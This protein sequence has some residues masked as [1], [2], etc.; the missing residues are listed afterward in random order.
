MLVSRGGVLA[1]SHR[2]EKM[3]SNMRSIVSDVILNELNDP[4]ISPLTSVT[5]VQMSGDLQ[6]AKV[7][8]SVLG[9]DAECRRTFAG[10][11]HAVGHIQRILAQRLQVRHCPQIRLR[12]DESLKRSAETIAMIDKLSDQRE[13]PGGTGH[14][15]G[16]DDGNSEGTDL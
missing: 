15:T 2:I 11:E 12:L 16:Q 3:A 13:A 4:R 5:R 7:F 1:R 6:I 10:L 14:D 9:S 8:V